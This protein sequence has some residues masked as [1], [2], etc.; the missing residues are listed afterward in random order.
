MSLISCPKCHSQISDQ[1]EN[2]PSCGYPIS[3]MARLR[4]GIQLIE[5]KK[6][7]VD[8]QSVYAWITMAIG[9]ILIVALPFDSLERSVNHGLGITFI[10]VG[11]LWCVFVGL[12]RWWSH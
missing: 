8:V 1:S 6:T 12:K 7:I 3:P 11:M 5:H 2:C 4:S 10:L 9:F